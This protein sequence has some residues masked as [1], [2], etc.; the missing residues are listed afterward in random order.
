M[1]YYDWLERD[2][3]SASVGTVF[4]TLTFFTHQNIGN[5]LFPP[6]TSTIEKIRLGTAT[7]LYF[8]LF[9]NTYA[10]TQFTQDDATLFVHISCVVVTD[11]VDDPSQ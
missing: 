9:I 10:H 6:P 3:S 4:H 1:P 8:V 11:F 7:E 2:K 5:V